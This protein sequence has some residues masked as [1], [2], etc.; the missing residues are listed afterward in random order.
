MMKKIFM[1]VAFAAMTITASAQK[2]IEVGFL[3]TSPDIVDLAWAFLVTGDDD[4][5]ECDQEATAGIKDALERYRQGESQ[6]KNV[7]LTVDKRN[8]F[9][10]YEFRYEEHLSRIE[11]C[12]W[13]EA[14]KKHKLFAYNRWSFSNGK[15][16]LGQYDELVFLRYNN[17]TKKMTMCE[18]PGFEV[19]YNNTIYA[20]PRTGKDITVT[21]WNDNGTKTKKTLKWNG[22][23]F[24]K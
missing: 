19:S 17:A 9:M 5:E 11:M 16:S 3:G 20:L 22:H 10:V 23:K 8:G 24:N 4:E 7:T 18:T 15:P 13:N 2:S 12:Y 6:D 1:W 21:K 14:D